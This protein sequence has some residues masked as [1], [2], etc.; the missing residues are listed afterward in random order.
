M[1]ALYHFGR[2]LMLIRDFFRS[3]EKLGVYWQQFLREANSIGIGSLVI[4]ILI[5]FFM[6][7][8]TTIQTSYQLTSALI[9]PEIIGAIVVNTAL[10]E[11]APTITSLV[12]AG[13][14][15]SSITSH[16]GTMRVTEQIDALEVMGINSASYLILPK[17]AAAVFTFPL[18]VICAAFLQTFGGLVAGHFSGEVIANDFIEGARSYFEPFQV[19]FMLVKS[20][21]FGFIIS[22]IASYQG[23]YISGG[24]LEVGEASTK[25][26]VYSCVTVLLADYVLAQIML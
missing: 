4:V 19:T 15:G 5:S 6:G 24:A 1:N 20:V 10:L 14:V 7:A 25:T 16:L 13:T 21:T 23:Y 11:L 8:V 9:P 12:L 17:I 18:L 22:S 26:V 3:P 2:Y